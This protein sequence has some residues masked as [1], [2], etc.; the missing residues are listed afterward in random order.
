VSDPLRFAYSQPEAFAGGGF[1]APNYWQGSA[2]TD[3]GAINNTAWS[4]SN[5]F[6][7]PSNSSGSTNYSRWF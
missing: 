5:T 2:G 4:M 7:A 1:S 3:F 6:D